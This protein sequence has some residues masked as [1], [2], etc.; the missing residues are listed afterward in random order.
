[1]Y[2][3]MCLLIYYGV[4]LKKKRKRKKKGVNVNFIRE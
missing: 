3:E 4:F 2:Y 1:M